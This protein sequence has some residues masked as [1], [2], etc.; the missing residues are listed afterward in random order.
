MN[1]S[2]N[3]NRYEIL[4]ILGQGASADV[5][6]ARHKALN[7][8]RVLKIMHQDMMLDARSRAKFKREAQL[9]ANLK[10]PAI[11]RIHDVSQTSS[12]LQIEMEYV[13]GQSL[14][15]HL[16]KCQTFPVPVVLAIIAGILEGLAHAHSARLQFDDVVYD[17][18]IHRD[19][20]PENVLIRQDGQ[21]VICDFG[22]AKL[23]AD[24]MS[25]TA[26]I[27]GS[28]AYMAPERLRGEPSTRSIDIFALG[29]TFYELLKNSRP[30]LAGNRTA[31]IENIL[32]WEI[33]DIAAELQGIDESVTEIILKALAR[34][35]ADR[36]KDA[37]EM[38]AA[39][40]PIYKLY[41]G[42]ATPASVIANYLLKGHF[43][44]AEFNAL[45]PEESPL[46]LRALLFGLALAVV[47]G[48][49]A[50]A[51][52][53][54]LG[55]KSSP[56]ANS[57]DASWSAFQEMLTARNWNHA[58]NHAGGLDS[59]RRQEAYYLLGRALFAQGENGRALLSASKALDI[60]F[61]PTVAAL[62]VEILLQ[63]GAYNLAAQELE[64][65]K[66]WI[67]RMSPENQARYHELK[68][69][70]KAQRK[71]GESGQAPNPAGAGSAEKR[72]LSGKSD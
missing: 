56:S 35:P 6:L 40:Q 33:V 49:F 7:E 29:V 8:L 27:S 5:Y 46:R 4:K 63:E 65:V 53:Y 9:A 12:K 2:I 48:G 36:Y 69:R 67:D 26:H 16:E 15:Q 68:L 21:P 1:A 55:D 39:V 51:H 24:L 60:G 22:V 13:E 32:K 23:G 50:L 3:D 57:A 45:V 25:Q 47:A 62:K 54:N 70:L 58:E 34:Q 38:A 37:S 17:G 14:R 41:H 19:L 18:V 72:Y 31:L 20:K 66:P 52:F 61:H 59:L 71:P 42:D 28:V 43:T 44:T 10:H 30:F 11:V 64:Q